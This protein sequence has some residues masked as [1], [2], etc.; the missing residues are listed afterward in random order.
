MKAR[1]YLKF[2]FAQIKMASTKNTYDNMCW[3]RCGEMETHAQQL[4]ISSGK[5]EVSEQKPKSSEG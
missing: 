2:G 1:I 5:L 4:K 3:L